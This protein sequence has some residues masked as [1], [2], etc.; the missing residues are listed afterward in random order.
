MYEALLH[1]DV[2]H[3]MVKGLRFRVLGFYGLGFRV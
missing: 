2:M 3:D 1:E